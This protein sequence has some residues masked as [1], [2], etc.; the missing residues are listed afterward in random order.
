MYLFFLLIVATL[1]MTSAFRTKSG[2]SR[3]VTRSLYMN[4]GK[5][6]DELGVLLPVGYWDPLGLANNISEEKFRQYRI[7]ELKHG[8]V[9][10]AAVVGYIVQEVVRFPGFL[11]PKEGL[12]FADIPNGV[13]A[14]GAVPL[15]GWIQILALIGLL[16]NG[17]CKQKDD[18][19]PGD[20]GTGYFGNFDKNENKLNKE[21]QNGRLAM[22]GIA[23]LITHDIAKPV[24]DSLF[25]LHHF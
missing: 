19:A 18:A 3:V 6:K 15:L 21:L 2:I 9:A 25:T 16:E 17:I 5:F 11:Y 7:A 24:G 8:R 12:K 23:E 1:A 22:L 10:M 20:F 14:I 4:N 13:A